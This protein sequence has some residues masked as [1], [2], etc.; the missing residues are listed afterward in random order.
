MSRGTKAVINF[1][2]LRHNF[3]VL[4]KLAQSKLVLVV[5][6]DAYGH[7]LKQVVTALDKAECF[8][9]ATIDEA[10]IVRSV[11]PTVRILLLEGY[12]DS[13]ELNLSF[14]NDFDC[15]IH[16]N[17]QLNLLLESKSSKNINVWLK[18]D[19]GMNRL[20]F[21]E[22]EFVNALALIE[23]SKNTKDIVL[24]SHLASANIKNSSFTKKQTRTFLKYNKGYQMSL[25]NSSALLNGV[26]LK[27]EWNRVGLALFGVSPIENTTAGKFNLKPVMTIKTNVIAVKNVKEGETIGYSQ[28]YTAE[29]DMKVA[30]I[31]IGY[32]D[33]FPWSLSCDAFVKLNNQKASIVG[34]VSMDMLAIDVTNL[35][36][37]LVGDSVLI[38][39]HDCDGQLPLEVLADYASTIPYV[40]LCQLTS[41]V[42]YQYVNK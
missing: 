29:N 16:Q 3:K 24:M 27:V 41:R 15:V 39:G 8:G 14:E 1:N 33:G 35:K 22:T 4:N 5:K 23:E 42:K 9:V 2:N 19:S 28:A 18:L 38:W 32:G 11:N 10:L 30:I 12:L 34:K 7:G 37:T 40:L 20:G 6:A 26:G 21:S 31:G 36:N 17:E 13:K 25:S